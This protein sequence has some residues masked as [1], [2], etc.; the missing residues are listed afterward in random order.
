M[1]LFCPLMKKLVKILF[2]KQ[3]QKYTPDI[4]FV[5][6]AV[7]SSQPHPHLQ[8]INLFY[9]RCSILSIDEENYLVGII[10]NT[11]R[12]DCIHV[13][14]Q[15]PPAGPA[16]GH[17]EDLAWANCP[18]RVY[19]DCLVDSPASEPEGPGGGGR[20]QFQRGQAGGAQQVLQHLPIYSW[21][22][23]TT[24]QVDQVQLLVERPPE[25]ALYLPGQWC[26]APLHYEERCCSS[27]STG[28]CGSAHVL[29]GCRGGNWW[30][31]TKLLTLWDTLWEEQVLLRPDTQGHEESLEQH[32]LTWGVQQ[33]HFATLGPNGTDA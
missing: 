11:F 1:V 26:S 20:A 9:K 33:C 29:L 14:L 8:S 24:D 10:I 31:L 30:W 7:L 18:V 27:D 6:T 2:W 19:P 16:T 28:R 25:A 23:G 17:F 21:V 22:P 4:H 3:F 13:T 15:H 5:K 32:D 12:H